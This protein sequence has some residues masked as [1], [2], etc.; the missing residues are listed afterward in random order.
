MKLHFKDEMA[1]EFLLVVIHFLIDKILF[2]SYDNYS[3][4]FV[5]KF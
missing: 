1:E 5:T 2:F 3:F 4:N